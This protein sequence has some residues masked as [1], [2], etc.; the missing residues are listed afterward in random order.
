MLGAPSPSRWLSRRAK[1]PKRINLVFSSATDNENRANRFGR[2]DWYLL[3]SDSPSK[4]QMKSSAK[5]IMIRFAFE[6]WFHFTLE[7]L[8]QH[9]MQIHVGE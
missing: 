3:A 6:S 2:T 7:P 5:R 4:Q 9:V 1:R 8:V